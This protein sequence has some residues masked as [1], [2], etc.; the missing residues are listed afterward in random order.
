MIK[1]PLTEWLEKAYLDF[2]Y[3]H[4][5]SA[6]D[7]FADHLGIS[8]GY[9]SQILNGYKKNIAKKTAILISQRLNDYSLL[10]LLGYSRPKEIAVPFS[11]LPPEFVELLKTIDLEIEKT[12]R[13]RHQQQVVDE[14]Q[15]EEGEGH[16]SVT[17]IP[18]FSLR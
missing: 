2:Q 12:L 8:R 13:E 5:R 10:D 7:V 1:S 16:N 4:G 14:P 18:Y 11:S 6:L 9:L 17:E 3:S 15:G